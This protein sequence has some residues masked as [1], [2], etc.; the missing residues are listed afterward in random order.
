MNK[1]QTEEII[2]YNEELK[3]KIKTQYFST[4]QKLIR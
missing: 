3:E 1:K 2:K 4:H